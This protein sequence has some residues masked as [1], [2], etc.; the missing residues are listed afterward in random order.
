MRKQILA[1][2]FT[3]LTVTAL[4]NPVTHGVQAKEQVVYVDS[5]TMA[6]TAREVEEINNLYHQSEKEVEISKIKELQLR[7]ELHYYQMF[8]GLS[9]LLGIAI[10]TIIYFVVS[11]RRRI[12]AMK[13][14]LKLAEA[15]R[16]I[17][18]LESER[19]RL[20]KDLHDSVANDLFGLEIKLSSQ[21]DK[22]YGWIV[23]EISKIR[24]GVR[25]I[26][27]EL[28][29]PEFSKLGL[30]EILSFYV[31]NVV[32]KSGITITY[33]SDKTLTVGTISEP[34]ALEV[35]RIVQEL[36]SNILKHSE[37]TSVIIDIKT[38]KP[39]RAMI[40]ITDN[41]I[42]WTGH[43]DAYGSGIKT[44]ADRAMSIGATIEYK[45]SSNQ[46]IKCI[47]FDK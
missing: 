24:D 44:V 4:A 16:Y 25:Y 27:H 34:V 37:A 2:V 47:T 33:N 10:V 3:A 32:R 31:D 6:D 5:A 42:E 30:D 12:M 22:D 26:S 9:A 1:Y 23:E 7:K 19:K 38:L 17:S 8:I 20:A 46:N 15:Q 41:G 29:P 11:N 13:Q 36:L 14:E 35:Y 40:C 28:M 18:G 43:A 21:S 39:T 45:R